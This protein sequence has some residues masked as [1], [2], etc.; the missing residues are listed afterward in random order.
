M[1]TVIENALLKYATSDNVNPQHPTSKGLCLYTDRDD[2]N[3]HCLAGQIWVDFGGDPSVLQESLG[4]MSIF[5]FDRYNE[6]DGL[7]CGVESFVSDVIPGITYDDVKLLSEA[8]QLADGFCLEVFDKSADRVL[9]GP[10]SSPSPSSGDQN[11]E[12][13]Q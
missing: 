2:P 5:A 12:A 9:R 4:I 6:A 10:R 11:L 3:R 7:E 1:G 13:V 8:Q